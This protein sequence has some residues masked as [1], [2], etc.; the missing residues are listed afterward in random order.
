MHYEV[1]VTTG[2]IIQ[3]EETAAELE[4]QAADQAAA[5]AAQE[6]RDAEEAAQASLVELARVK[7]IGLGLSEEEVEA[8][9]GPEP[10]VI[11]EDITNLD[12]VTLEPA[13]EEPVVEPVADPVVEDEAAE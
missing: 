8:I 1:N 4:Q 13:V 3:R 5:S 2:Q 9:V 12:P 7:L 6:A 11:D 10:K